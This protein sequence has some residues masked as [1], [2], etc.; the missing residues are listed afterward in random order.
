DELALR[1]FLRTTLTAREFVV[2]EAET[3][4][5]AKLLVTS[6]PPEII[7]LDLGLPDGDGIDFTRELREWSQI[8]I[9]VISA[10]G[11]EE[12]K[13]TALDAGADDYLTKPF[14]VNELM[15]RIRVAL[16]HGQRHDKYPLPDQQ[17]IEI[18]FL[19]MD[20]QRREVFS[21]GALVALTPIEYRL[22]LLMASNAGRVLTHRY[23]LKEVW[24]AGYP[25]QPHTLR[26]FMAQLRRKVEPNPTRPQLLL[27]EMGVGYRLRDSWDGTAA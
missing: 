21:Q 24:G 4:R 10:R 12:D 13:V 20:L 23:I 6:H 9:V 22:L 26:V 18:G 16:R 8:P 17:V 15:A 11:R 19:R 3:L 2:E 1:R 14:G 25:H 7:L 5:Q 27:T